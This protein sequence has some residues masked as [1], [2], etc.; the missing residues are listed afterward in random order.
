MH[1]NAALLEKLYRGLDGKD[2]EAM[3]SCYHPDATFRDIAFKLR[4]KKEIHA[5]WHMIE[6]TD[7]RATFEVLHAD[8]SNGAVDLVDVYTFSDTGKKVRNVIRSDFRFRD[9]LI[10]EHEDTC[11]PLKWGVQALGV[12]PGVLMSLAPPAR[13]FMARRKLDAFIADHRQ[14]Y[15]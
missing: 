2:H 11:S 3:A 5:M 4:G 10:V 6:G 13:R 9:G 7:L 14:A 8:E 1:A 12:V 15:G